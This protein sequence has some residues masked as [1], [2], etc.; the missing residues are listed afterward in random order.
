MNCQQTESPQK[1]QTKTPDHQNKVWSA[2]AVEYGQS[3]IQGLIGLQKTQHED[4]IE[5][6]V[7][8]QYYTHTLPPASALCGCVTYWDA[9][10]NPTHECKHVSRVANLFIQIWFKHMFCSRT[11]RSRLKKDAWLRKQRFMKR[12]FFWYCKKRPCRWKESRRNTAGNYSKQ[13]KKKMSS[14]KPDDWSVNPFLLRH[15]DGSV[16]ILWENRFLAHVQT[17][18]WI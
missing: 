10:L 7:G 6:H 9:M 12:V 3:S 5:Y 15:A 17:E 16:R 1:A 4:C 14:P 11:I 8:I 18:D 13:Q 2:V